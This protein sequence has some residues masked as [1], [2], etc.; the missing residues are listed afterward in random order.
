MIMPVNVVLDTN[1]LVSA[2][3]S[4]DGKPSQIV[5]MIPDRKIIPCFCDAILL[6]YKAVLTRPSFCF[7]QDRVEQLLHQLAL[8]GKNQVAAKSEIP[9]ADESD[10]VFYDTAKAVE[11][12]LVTGNTK[13]FPCEPFVFSP[14]DFLTWY[15]N[16]ISQAEFV[17][18]GKRKA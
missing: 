4:A 1:V 10:R 7:S 14:A 9:L 8:F 13:H 2:L 3:W 18:E 17:D 6:E 12:V 11:A 5:H 15:T 16:T